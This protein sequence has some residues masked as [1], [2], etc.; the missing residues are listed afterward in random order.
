MSFVSEM[1]QNFGI[2]LIRIVTIFPLLLAVT[3]FMGRRTVGEMPVFDFLVV[4]ALGSV[5]GAD[6]AEPE[7]QH[8][9]TVFAI[10]CIA[11]LQKV[12]SSG[13]IRYRWFSKLISFEPVI[14]VYQ[15]K[16]V[17]SNLKKVKYTLDNVLQLLREEQIFDVSEVYLCVLEASGRISIIEQTKPPQQPISMSYPIVREGKILYHILPQLGMNEAWIQQQ[18]TEKNIILTDVFLATVDD[19][20]T[21]SITKYEEDVHQS[22]PPIKQ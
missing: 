17:Q 22:L 8:I 19:N 5:V 21:L 11:L 2:V 9:P 13:S 12:I 7:I 4:I 10:I 18:L 1:F 14:I 6:I 15:G 3:L 20:K 16:I